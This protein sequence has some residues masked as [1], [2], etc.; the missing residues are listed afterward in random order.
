[1]QVVDRR[2]FIIMNRP[3]ER[4]NFK[5]ISLGNGLILSYH[6]ELPVKIQDKTILLG[7]AFSSIAETIDLNNPI[8]DRYHWA[9]RW[10]LIHNGNLYL[11]PCGSLGVFYSLS[12]DSLICSSSLRL[13]AE[14]TGAKWI[15][16]YQI[17]YNDGLPY[18]D[19][20]PIP[21]TPYDGIKKM[22]PTQYLDLVKH[23]LCFEDE[24]W[25]DRFSKYSVEDLYA[26]LKQQLICI[27]KNIGKQYGR[28][29]WI[30]LTAGVDSR[31]CIAIAKEAGLKFGAYTAL[32]DNINS[33]DK[34][35]PKK[36]CR[37]LGITHFYMNDIGKSNFDR[38]GLYNLHCGGKVSVGTDKAQFI[39]GND[40]PDA[41]LSIV[42]WGTAWEL[43]GRNFW[44]TFEIGKDN[45]ERFDAWDKYSGGAVRNSNIHEKSL[46]EWLD[47]VETHSMHTMDWRQRMYY[48]QRIGSWLSSSYQAI[49]LFDSDRISPVNCYDV[50]GLLINLVD[51]TFQDEARS[52]KRYQVRMIDEFLPQIK[53]IPYEKKANILKRLI[54]KIQKIL[55]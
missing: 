53:D 31:T 19:Y 40:V 39:A 34:R 1:M 12:N 36:I 15:A 9:G 4:E 35:A 3:Y 33:W 22:Y 54:R 2:Q 24:S 49:D 14:Q 42:L 8:N 45:T 13:M 46:K 32:R 5:N 6:E 25:Y 44:G 47:Y 29:I 23:T 20:Y 41:D 52:D 28:N 26:M 55:K 51:K 7:L 48:E 27:F 50:F 30:P 43:Y 21:Y 38:E 10:V 37:R 11:D 17:K 18:M 16:N